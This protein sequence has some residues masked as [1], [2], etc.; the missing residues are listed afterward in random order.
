MS[1][2]ARGSPAVMASDGKRNFRSVRGSPMKR[3]LSRFTGAAASWVLALGVICA[4]P[5]FA[6]E[7]PTAIWSGT[8]RNTAGAPIAGAEVQLAGSATAESKT[9]TDGSF[10]L[11]PLP[12]GQYKLT[13][14]DN[15]KTTTYA[16]PIVL[17]SG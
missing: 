2:F 8:L 15:G 16:Q 9:V 14:V 10:R 1:Q 4:L 13:I 12:N 17:A 6:Q 3:K 5:L 11:A 7:Q